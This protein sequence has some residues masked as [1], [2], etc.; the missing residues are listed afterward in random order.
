MPQAKPNSDAL[1]L[2]IDSG[3]QSVRALVFDLQGKLLAK[4]KTELEPYTSPQAGWAEQDVELYWRNVCETCQQLW[5]QLGEDKQRIAGV[6]MTSQ[7]ATVVNLDSAGKP[8]RPAINWLDQRRAK[9]L[10]PIGKGWDQA[11]KLIG[12]QGL[13]NHFRSQAESNWLRMEQQELWAQ[14]DKF[15]FLSGYLHYRMSGDF[16]DS[17]ASQVGY[18]PFS[19]R[20]QR[21]SPGWNWKW[22]ATGIEASQ[23]PELVP[24]SSA[25]G[26]VSRE[27]A[28]QTGLPEGLPIIA[29]AADKACE[30]IGSG[31][32]TPDQGALSYGTTATINTTSEKYVEAVPFLPA[33]PSAIPGRYCTEVQ[34]FRGFWMVNWFKQQFGLAEQIQAESSGAIVESLFDDLIAD[35]PPGSEGL[36]LQPYWSP[37]VKL[38]GPEARGA[39]IG[40]GDQHGRAHVYRAMLEGLAYALREGAECI[41][42]RSGVKLQSLRVSGGGS[43]S[44]AMMQIT[45][46]VFGLPAERPHTYE[47]SGLGAAMALAVGLGLHA[48]YASAIAAMSHDGDLF[49]PNA[50]AHARYT[51]LYRQVYR[52]LY[53]RLSPLYRSLQAITGY[54]PS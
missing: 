49:Q 40:F 38:P 53:G 14:T 2:A 48:D 51:Q 44:N 50:D 6:A 52:K 42:K 43:Q 13:V 30:I 3:T 15:L 17:C 46:D 54:P 23:L 45:A 5:P 25:M 34:V 28:A 1:L 9:D 8:L 41:E 4:S 33:Y 18:V 12:Q 47:T 37:G 31:C 27:A 11:F 22:R 10:P 19:Y 20:E 16:R 32:L 36:V 29:A 39:I 21:W 7:R 35:V 24:A 26:V